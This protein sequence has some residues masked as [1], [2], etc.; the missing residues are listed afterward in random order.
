MFFLFLKHLCLLGEVEQSVLGQLKTAIDQ[1]INKYILN[2]RSKMAM[3]PGRTEFHQKNIAEFQKFL[4]LR[5]DFEEGSTFRELVQQLS[6]LSLRKKVSCKQ[7][8]N[9]LRS[10][11]RD[12]PTLGHFFS[13]FEV[14]E[15]ESTPSSA[16]SVKVEE[17]SRVKK[18][19]AM[20]KEEE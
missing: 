7:A 18:E 19:E 4:A 3:E 15:G 13:D 16:E 6:I 2:S 9:K 10:V 11:I 12:L 20:V 5:V 17:E 1:K 8:E 14:S